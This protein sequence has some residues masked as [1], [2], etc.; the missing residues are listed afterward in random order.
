MSD[1]KPETLSNV[2]R[3]RSRYEL[4]M[5]AAREARRLNELARSNSKELK[6]RVTDVAWERL[7]NDEISFTYEPPR[8]LDEVLGDDVSA[9][10]LEGAVPAEGLPV[11]DLTGGGEAE[12][13]RNPTPEE[14]A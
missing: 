8:P 13:P 5:I 2:E 9:E 12:T 14:G 1:D 10:D 7:T 4:V 11:P 3:A 6:R